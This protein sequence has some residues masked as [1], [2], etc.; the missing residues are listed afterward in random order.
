MDKKTLQKAFYATFPVMAGYL[1]LGIGFGIL[2]HTRGY[3]W[4]WSLLMSLMIYAG[5]MQYVAIDL[6]G[7]S[8]NLITVT[9]MT[10]VVNA[11]HL[12]Y[13]ISMLSKYK[14]IGKTKP[15]LIFALTDETYSLVCQEELPLEVDREQYY[16]LVSIL[17]HAY[18]IVGSV[19][20]AV[21]GS[22]LSFNSMGVEFS[23]TALFIV[24]MLEQWESTANHVPALTGLFVSVACLLLF[25]ANDF[26]IPA[27]ISITLALLLERKWS[28]EEIR[29]E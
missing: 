24:S 18:W 13:G 9:L 17:N 14:D 12:F 19:L 26:L 4:Y 16:F 1:V 15:Y 20:G 11:R 6:L 28:K 3:A 2:M 8:A 25:G 23:M 10:L 22:A 7:A 27:L 5:S 21:L 29:Y